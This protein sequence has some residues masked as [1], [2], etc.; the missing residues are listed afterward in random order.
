MH[1][2]GRIEFCVL[3]VSS[4]RLK[5]CEIAAL[6]GKSRNSITRWLNLGLCQER[7]DPEFAA[8]LNALDAAI[9]RR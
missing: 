4:Y 6:L 7:D 2:T 9:S 1:V 5:A 3:A 8:R